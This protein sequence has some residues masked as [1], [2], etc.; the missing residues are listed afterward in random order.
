[1][2]F[3]SIIIISH[4]LV[5]LNFVHYLREPIR[6]WQ[7]YLAWTSYVLGHITVPIITAVWLYVFMLLVH[8][9]HT[10]LPLITKYLWSFNSFTIPNAA[11]WFIHMNGEN[12]NADYDTPGYAAGLIRVD[13]ALGTHLTSNGFHASIV[14]GALPSL[15]SAM[16]VMTF[17]FVGY[18]S[19]WYILLN[20]WHLCLL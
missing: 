11:P 20:F 18:Y 10:V 6:L 5:L 4:Q 7:D 19:R 8:L 2:G 3:L 13:I 14:F 12:A 9:K 16:A 15:H 1:M 17:F